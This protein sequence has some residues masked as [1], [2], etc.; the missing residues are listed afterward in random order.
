M[1]R[2][3]R[4]QAR[5]AEAYPTGQAGIDAKRISETQE[6]KWSAEVAKRIHAQRISETQAHIE[7]ERQRNTSGT[8]GQQPNLGR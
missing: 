7:I 1:P 8:P 5:I 6:A 4:V 3:A 2:I